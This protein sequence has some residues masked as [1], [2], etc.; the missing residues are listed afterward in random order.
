MDLRK[1]GYGLYYNSMASKV[2]QSHEAMYYQNVAKDISERQ[3]TSD[4]DELLIEARKR[5]KNG[6]GDYGFKEPVF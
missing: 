1:K 6:E 3:T 4:L 2:R 5:L